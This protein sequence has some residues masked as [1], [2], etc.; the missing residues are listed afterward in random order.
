MLN[1]TATE[2]QPSGSFQPQPSKSN[3]QSNI[4][5][6]PQQKSKAKKQTVDNGKNVGTERRHSKPSQNKPEAKR[7]GS[8]PDAAHGRKG[9]SSKQNET[10]ARVDGGKSRPTNNRVATA[11]K[12]KALDPRANL[13][14]SSIKTK[15]TSKVQHME[16]T[17]CIAIMEA[18]EPV[19]LVTGEGSALAIANGC[20]LYVQWIGR[21][22]QKH[23]EVTL[24]GFD[25]GSCFRSFRLQV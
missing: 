16:P 25:Q 5:S 24:I 7:Q 15:S 8:V 3:P 13:I 21:C 12:N 22:L 19:N 14:A 10:K 1:P 23:D 11:G 6:T 17:S 4:N 20:E 2:F 18:I 9:S